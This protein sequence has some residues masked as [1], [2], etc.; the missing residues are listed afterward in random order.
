[1]CIGLPVQVMESDGFIAKCKGRNGIEN[2]NMML[3]GEQQQG[4]WV[5]NFLGSAREVISAD[6]AEKINL[7]FDA[8]EKV[9][10]TNAEDI[11]IDSYFPDLKKH[12]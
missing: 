1:M 11:D 5:V 2:V 9:M 6:D 3:V 7:A 10:S 8:L 4:T 12:Q